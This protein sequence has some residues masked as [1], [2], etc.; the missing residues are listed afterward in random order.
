MVDVEEGLLWIAELDCPDEDEGKEC[1]EDNV[2]ISAPAF[3][4]GAEGHGQRPSG[5]FKL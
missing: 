1:C 5:G 3:V 2:A 4:N